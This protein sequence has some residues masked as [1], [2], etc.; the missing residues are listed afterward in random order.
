[1]GRHARTV[2]RDARVT[3]G[4]GGPVSEMPTKRL[5]K[6]DALL[7]QINTLRVTC[8]EKGRQ[9]T[10]DAD[11]AA[12]CTASEIVDGLIEAGYLSGASANESYGVVNGR[13][14]RVIPPG[15]TLAASDV[16]D[17]EVLAI[18]KDLNGA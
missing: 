18:T 5:P 6:E 1:M 10:F 2:E 17:G 9:D 7:T 16:M 14:G 15:Q 11:V 8:H 13:T 3:G 4:V 12:D